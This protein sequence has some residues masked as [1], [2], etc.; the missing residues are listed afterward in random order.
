MLAA[1]KTSMREFVILMA[2]LMSIVSIS[3]DAMLPALGIIGHDLGLQNPNHAQYIISVIFFGMMLGQLICGP[4]SDDIGRKKILYAGLFVFAIGSVVCYTAKSIEIM[5]LGRFIQGVG[6]AGPNV[7]AIAIVRDKYS[8]QDMARIM[9]LVMMIFMAMPAVAPAM[10]QGI[11]MVAS[12]R[13]IYLVYLIY[14][15][16]LLVWLFLRLEE[17]LTPENRI[18]FSFKNFAHG[19]KEIASNRTTFCYTICMSSESS[20]VILFMRSRAQP[21]TNLHE[22]LKIGCGH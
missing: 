15:L 2:A 5:L 22:E 8:G 16:I 4:L 20:V 18:K 21:C 19:A 1:K 10:G 14:A 12:W 11:M 9:S 3:I 17:T 6:I 7:A 13:A